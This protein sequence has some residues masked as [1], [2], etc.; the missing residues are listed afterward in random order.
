ME[1]RLENLNK[2]FDGRPVLKDITYTFES[3]KLYVIKGVSGCGK[4]TLLNILGGV[5]TEYDGTCETGGVRTAMIFQKS[6]LA[7]H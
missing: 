3:G 5:D 2:S 6:L 4:T 7:Y 1:I